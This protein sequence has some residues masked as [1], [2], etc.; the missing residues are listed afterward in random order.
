MRR[1]FF[2]C[3]REKRGKI[4]Q[5][6]SRG[7]LQ[8]TSVGKRVVGPVAEDDVVK[9]SDAEELAALLDARRDGPVFCGRRW[10]A[11]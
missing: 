6:P 10:V 11:A 9:K 2:S 1:S 5:E 8:A 7:A 4:I 3:E